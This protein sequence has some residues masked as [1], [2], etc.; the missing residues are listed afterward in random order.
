MEKF[1]ESFEDLT[2]LCILQKFSANSMALADKIVKKIGQKMA[3]DIFSV[4]DFLFVIYRTN[5]LIESKKYFPF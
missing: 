5:Q 4:Q 2:S 3:S 1:N